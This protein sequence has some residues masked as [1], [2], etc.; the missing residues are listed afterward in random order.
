MEAGWEPLVVEH[1]TLNEEHPVYTIQVCINELYRLKAIRAKYIFL[2]WE[3][4]HALC[5][6]LRHTWYPSPN[7]DFYVLQVFGVYVASLS[8]L[9]QSEEYAEA[10]KTFE[11]QEYR[12]P[13]LKKGEAIVL[14]AER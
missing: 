8:E 4:Y 1:T 11:Y 5:L 9:P 2:S 10:R 13:T 7:N 6:G 3:D 12:R 14:Y